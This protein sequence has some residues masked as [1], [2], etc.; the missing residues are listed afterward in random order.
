MRIDVDP[1]LGLYLRRL[2][3]IVILAL[4]GAG[5]LHE[6]LRPYHFWWHEAIIV[7]LVLAAAA[8]AGLIVVA[9]VNLISIIVRTGRA[10]RNRT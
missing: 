9:A 8:T 10:G 1:R 6:S 5:L 4:A 7:P 3:A 2:W